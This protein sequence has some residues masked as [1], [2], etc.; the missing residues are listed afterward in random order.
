M[1]ASVAVAVTAVAVLNTPL[2][3]QRATGRLEGTLTEKLATR[4][5]SAAW[6]SLVQLEPAGGVT[7]NARPD[8]RGHFHVDSL[9]AGR[10]LVQVGVPT[11]DSLELALPPSE[12]RIAG[13]ETARADFALPSGARL[14]DV[15]C[16]GVKLA[17]GKGVIAGRI[18]DADTERPIAGADVVASWPE[19]SIDSA[20]L[21]TTTQR[22]IAVA[23][24]GAQGEYRMC[25][26]PT[27]RLLSLQLQH[28][29]R[30][31]AVLRVTVT[32]DEGVAVRDLSLSASSAPTIVAL[33]STA[34]VA[35]ANHDSSLADL[36]LTGTARL[37]GTV[38][39]AGGQPLA[40]VEVRVRD[41]RESASTDSAGHFAIDRLPAGTQIMIVRELG[42]AL[43]ELPVELRPSATLTRDVQLTRIV[44]LD[45]VK[46]LAA[47]PRYAEFERNMRTNP[48]GKFMTMSEVQR[49]NAATTGELIR[50]FGWTVARKG[51]RTN[52]RPSGTVSRKCMNA[53]VVIDGMDGLSVDDVQPKAIAGIEVYAD[54][55]TAPAR[56]SG[57][58]E[59]G[60]V[61]IW[62]R[63]KDDKRPTSPNGLNYNGYP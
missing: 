42:Y 4:S 51:M 5:V 56:Y 38:R 62:L 20:T 3:A 53:N 54:P 1:R 11:L 23:R 12:V 60:V 14:R 31:G 55:T 30:A 39:G 44:R 15:V 9:P 33:D 21:E 17:Q 29:G 8:E 58:A 49:R 32:D 40:N 50:V 27:G 22:Q 18:V 2:V 26:V 16:T 35:V 48:M 28:A 7:I 37:R 10:Y 47:K 61:V 24:S 63:T 34:R 46:V 19:I 57:N 41:A 13:G 6:I 36:Q 43:A 25:G 52:V 59:C 45:S